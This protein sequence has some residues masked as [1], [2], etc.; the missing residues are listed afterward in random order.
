[1]GGGGTHNPDGVWPCARA[2]PMYGMNRS[3]EL[4]ER[5]SPPA[6]IHCKLPACSDQVEEGR[7]KPPGLGLLMYPR[8]TKY[9]VIYLETHWENTVSTRTSCEFSNAETHLLLSFKC[10]RHQKSNTNLITGNTSITKPLQSCRPS[11]HAWSLKNRTTTQHVRHSVT[12][13]GRQFVPSNELTAH[14]C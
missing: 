4:G 12:L 11:S 1:M 14:T 10:F 2:L 9:A 5:A 7:W 6:T 3:S 8:N 13:P